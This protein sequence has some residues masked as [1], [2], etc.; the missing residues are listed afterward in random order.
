MPSQLPS[1]SSCTA[2]LLN[3][4]A[5]QPLQLLPHNVTQ[6]LG[7]LSQLLVHQHLQQRRESMRTQIPPWVTERGYSEWPL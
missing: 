4:P 5:A 1:V 3:E 7:I 2:H 6:P